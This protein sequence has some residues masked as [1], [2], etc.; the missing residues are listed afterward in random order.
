MRN[1]PLE[2]HTI[3]TPSG[4]LMECPMSVV[5]IA[6]RRLCLFSGGYLRLAPVALIRWGV[7]Q[8]HRA[9][10]PLIALVHPR[11]IDPDQPRLPLSLRRRFKCYVNLKST[12]R[13]IEWLCRTYKFHSMAKLVETVFKQGGQAAASG[14]LGPQAGLSRA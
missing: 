12:M 9:G 8:L 11:E 6:R 7:G 10:R 2:P 13:K 14:P 4:P 1:A 3:Q 5:E